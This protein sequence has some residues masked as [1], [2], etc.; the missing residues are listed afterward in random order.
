M[1]ILILLVKRQADQSQEDTMKILLKNQETQTK[2]E[3]S[4]E[5]I[6]KEFDYVLEQVNQLRKEQSVSL[7]SMQQ[8]S[9][10][11]QSMNRV[12]TNTKARGNWGEYQLDMLLSIYAG[13]NPNIYSTQ[14][15]LSNGKIADAI[16]HIPNSDKVLCIDSKFPMEN[17]LRLDDAR[18]ESVFRAFKSNVKKH[19]DAISTKYINME[20]MNQA[21]LFIPSEAIYQFICANCEDTLNY[22]LS[23]HVLITSPTTL[24][25]VIYTLLASTKDFYRANHIKEIE[26]NIL[27]LQEDMNRL[28][29]RSEKA[30]SSLESLVDQFHQVST[31]AHKLSSRLN[32]MADGKE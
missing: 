17:Y 3:D 1:I 28:V 20:T 24:V 5:Y 2:S 32:K 25:G 7:Q 26:K 12:M 29:T 21:I 6:E 10:T 14:Y 23:K 4:Q 13:S 15:T 9:H 18:D 31:S 11:I 16:L 27:L 8:V 30:E 19:I 22:A